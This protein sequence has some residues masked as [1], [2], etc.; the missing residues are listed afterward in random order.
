[1]ED[2]V[3]YRRH[4]SPALR[5]LEVLAGSPRTVMVWGRRC[6]YSANA[7]PPLLRTP[8][9]HARTTPQPIPPA[10]RAALT[11]GNR[12]DAPAKRH[13]RT[14]R[15][16]QPHHRLPHP[17]HLLPLIGRLTQREHLRATE[18]GEALAWTIGH[19]PD[20]AL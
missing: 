6:I 9:L 15:Q 11:R 2:A 14:T 12:V 10:D 19:A 20:E 17:A 13:R 5:S 16:G 4:C 18:V 3:N 8:R 7:P 1:N